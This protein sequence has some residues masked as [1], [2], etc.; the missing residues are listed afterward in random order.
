MA[1]VGLAGK[2]PDCLDLPVAGLSVRDVP[3]GSEALTWWISFLGFAG[4]LFM[5][6]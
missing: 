3:R 2:F 4:I 5:E 6:D 1:E